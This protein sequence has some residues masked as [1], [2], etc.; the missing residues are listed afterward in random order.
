MGAQIDCVAITDHNSGDWVDKLKS[1]YSAMKAERPDGFR[2]LHLFPGVEISVNGGIH[3]LAIFDP[4]ANQNHITALLGDVG[5]P[6]PEHGD[7]TCVT[8]KSLR[9]VVEAVASAGALAIP[10]H[11]DK[12]KGVLQLASS[13]GPARAKMDANTL[14]EV[15]S[16]NQILAAEFVD[17]DSKTPA[18]YEES[19]R[20]WTVVAGSDS[21]SF[22]GANRPGSRFTWVKMGAPPCLEGL[23]LALL[24]GS[25]VGT[26]WC[27]ANDPRDPNSLSRNLIESV[28]IEE[29][30]YMG[31][32]SAA[33]LSLNPWLNTLIGG[34]GTGKSTVVH[35]LRLAYRRGD[36]LESLPVGNEPL[37]SF[38]DFSKESKG[39][40]GHGGVQADTKIT[41]TVSGDD[42]RYRLTW[43][44]EST[45][46]ER[47]N[48][49]DW[50]KSESQQ[51]SGR[52]FPIR[53]YSQGQIAALAVE[54][55][56]ALLQVIDDG[57]E[58]HE[59]KTRL[60]EAKKS[61]LALRAQGRELEVKLDREAE[62]RAQ[63]SE[64][65]RKL[66]GF[67]GKEHALVLEGFQLRQR[68]DRELRRQLD[69]ARVCAASL[70]RATRE[71]RLDDAP[72]GLFPEEDA[73]G[74]LASRAIDGL[75]TKV[76]V[77]ADSTREAYETL[78]AAIEEAA[79]GADG[80]PWRTVVEEASR[81]YEELVT[82]LQERGVADPGQYGRLVQEN[83][84]LEKEAAR[85]ADLATKRK[86]IK[87][88][89]ESQL[90]SVRDARRALTRKREDFLRV[91]LG[92]N[93][94]VRIKMCAYGR[95][96]SQAE[97]SLRNVLRLDEGT[98]ATDILTTDDATGEPSGGIVKELLGSLA[99]TPEEMARQ[100][101]E[102]LDKIR[103]TL[104]TAAAGDEQV[105]RLS[106]T[107]A[108]KLGREM[109]SRPEFADHIMLWSPEDT[110]EVT[111]S[112]AGDG[113][114]FLPLD[115][116]SAG[117]RAAAMLAFLLTHG[118]E[119]LVLDQPED[120]LDNHLIYDLVV[121]QILENKQR[122]QLIVVTHNPNI[123]I[124]GSAELVHTF[125]F[126]QGQC[127]VNED[128]TGPLQKS[129]VQRQV[130]QIMEGGTV[131]FKGRYRRLAKELEKDA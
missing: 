73:K 80:G 82:E 77:A 68:Q 89:A 75:Q 39:R 72:E 87:A 121:K 63:I 5:Y 38:T 47:W 70:E 99:E 54:N 36:E 21:H 113:T 27:G 111:Y 98:F 52:R 14:R 33:K 94:Y 48:G 110:L 130:C 1:T 20:A 22:Q 91:N 28:E 97:G 106:R 41:V 6:A 92:E 128:G 129:G 58:S 44:K 56:A 62:V 93:A 118:D 43:G 25:D 35:A 61:F 114:E 107:L 4:S 105:D 85:L 3:L 119:P 102:R 8:R 17:P 96:P 126:Q 67:E 74:M 124:N 76:A 30:R 131:A 103:Q 42:G 125:E 40:N 2:E 95:D 108:K 88:D 49:K 79:L 9:E 66:A 46:V 104:T 11:A 32:G 64:V 122:R 45:P 23:R 13:D 115:Q 65:R 86:T 18:V 84:R 50:E 112:R 101:E 109:A 81:S 69:A 83:Q 16:S 120:D 37:R 71:L 117:Q 123:V 60:G 78:L 57:A 127:R 24:D 55:S 15:L 90:H 29:A 100:M 59:E 10:A 116:G 51:V 26:L 7:T 31:R 53:I 19:G 12:E 34:R